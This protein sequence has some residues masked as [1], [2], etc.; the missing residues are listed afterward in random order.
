[1]DQAELLELAEIVAEFP[2]MT[3]GEPSK[4][5]QRR[6][7]G[8]VS[9]NTIWS[10]LRRIEFTLKKSCWA[11]EAAHKSDLR[12]EGNSSRWQKMRR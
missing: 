10:G 6:R 1:L 9:V 12:W 11:L 5:L 2:G 8:S 4:L 3:S 7:G